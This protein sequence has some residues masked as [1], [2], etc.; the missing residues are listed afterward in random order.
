[1][2]PG[3]KETPEFQTIEDMAQFWESHDSTEFA[4][5]DI[6]EVVYEPKRLVLSVRFEPGDMIALTRAARRLGMDRSTFVR[7]IVK[8]FLQN[9]AGNPGPAETSAASERKIAN[10]RSV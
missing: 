4:A 1:M 6:Q 5:G 3:K 7:F 9:E 2:T 8:Q 10:Q